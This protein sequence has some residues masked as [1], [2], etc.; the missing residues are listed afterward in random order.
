MASYQI[1]TIETFDFT[2]PSEWPN[3]IRRFER[4]RHA[5]GLAGKSEESQV[6]TLIYS[7]GDK[8]DDILQ[9]FKLSEEDLKTYNTVKQKF[10]AH[11]VKRRNVIFE[12][13]KFN[14]RKQEAGESVNSF[15]TDLHCLARYCNY[16][17][18][19]D[20]MIRD[21]IVVGIRD[22]KL[23]QRMQ[24]EAELT[25]TKAIEIASQSEAVKEQQSTVRGHSESISVDVIKKRQ[26]STNKSIPPQHKFRHSAMNSFKQAQ[27]QACTR[28]GQTPSHE[29]KFCPARDSVCHKCHKKGHYKALCR[30]KRHVGEV[31]VDNESELENDFLGVIHSETDSLSSQEAP[32]TKTLTLNNRNLDF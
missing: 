15:I 25:L 28:C 1:P 24:L 9:S 7:M 18:L 17:D 10:D 2:I 8:A 19:H 12:R 26:F 6:N 27:S 16:G 29:K 23:S 11:F 20:E 31:S 3:W 22:S 5:S 4:F 21:R 30:S 32:W 13:A 14:S